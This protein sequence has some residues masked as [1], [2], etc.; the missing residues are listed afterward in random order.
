MLDSGNE[1]GQIAQALTVVEQKY[2]I[3]SMT[4]E[5]DYIYIN[6]KALLLP[7]VL[8]AHTLILSTLSVTCE[9]VLISFS[10]HRRNSINS[11]S[12][13]I[14]E[15]KKQKECVYLYKSDRVAQQNNEQASKSTH[16]FNTQIHLTHID[17]V[18]TCE[19]EQ[20]HSAER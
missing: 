9:R 20:Q 4:R 14:I 8:W 7:V 1:M 11:H 2:R 13:C 17:F 18:Y 3:L 6:L 10:N 16:Y 5:L 19:V 15:E 12:F